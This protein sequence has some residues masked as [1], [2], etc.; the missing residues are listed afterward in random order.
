MRAADLLCLPSY[1]ETFGMVVLEVW[2]AGT[3][4]LTSDIT[5]LTTLVGPSR[6]GWMVPLDATRMASRL[7]RLV[8]A[9]DQLREAVRLGHEHSPGLHSA[10]RVAERHVE[11]YRQALAGP[12]GRRQP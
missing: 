7:D 2:R 6:G 11:V 5:A 3:P 4:V 9:P 12:G 8:A 10:A 1:T